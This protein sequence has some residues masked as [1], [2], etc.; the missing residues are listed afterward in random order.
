MT[1]AMSYYGL[2]LI[3]TSL[4]TL[5]IE[6]HS[7]ATGSSNATAPD[8]CRMLTDK[9]Y[10]SLIFTTFG[11]MFG[12]PLLLLLL[13]RFGRR[14]ICTIN[15]SSASI[16]FLMLLLIP[17]HDPWFINMIT[18]IARMFI[19]A[20]FGLMYLYTMEV[21]PTVVRAIAVGCASSMARVG[22]MI[23]PYLAQVLIK[24][25]FHGTIGIYVTVT[26]LA[27]LFALL[28]PIETRGRELKVSSL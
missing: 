21:Y 8:R 23:T 13:A 2:I 28:L 24:Q 18:F 5:G 19:N 22:A 17:R 1:V 4:M 14:I 15:F 9:D 10:Q 11:E 7:P 3:N 20:Q 25:T 27:A 16:C 26:L 12:V 6:N